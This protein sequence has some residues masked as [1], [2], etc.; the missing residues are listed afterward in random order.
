MVV[1]MRINQDNDEARKE[2]TSTVLKYWIPLQSTILKYS[3]VVQ[4]RIYQDDDEARKE[5][6]AA[7][8]GT[9]TNVFG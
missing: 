1:Q 2:I 6:I 4:M 7:I 9:A 5:E 3:M 8:G